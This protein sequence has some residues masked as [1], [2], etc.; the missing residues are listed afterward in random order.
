MSENKTRPTSTSVEDFIESI[1]HPRRRADAL[2]ALKIYREVTGLPA[3]MWG[4]SIIGFGEYHYEY[5]SGRNGRM[6]AAG[7]SPRKAN[8][9]FYVGEQF[10]Q[11][12]TLYTRLGKHKKTVACLYINK[13]DDVDL[14]VLREI[15]AADY[16]VTINKSN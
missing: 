16:A 3:V 11:A 9:T 6:L 5:E 14:D 2:T 1:G 4:A 10:D 15:I 8:M 12:E 7:F 13:L